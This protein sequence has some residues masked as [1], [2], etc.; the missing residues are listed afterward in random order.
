LS[1]NVAEKSNVSNIYESDRT[2]AH[3]QLIL[4]EYSP[5]ISLSPISTYQ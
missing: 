2:I 1:N 5:Q 4:Q 3:K